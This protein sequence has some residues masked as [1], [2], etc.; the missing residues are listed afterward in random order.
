M[1]STTFPP[2]TNNT[3]R[4]TSPTQRKIPGVCRF[5]E[6][7]QNPLTTLSFKHRVICYL[8]SHAVTCPLPQVRATILKSLRDVP[9]ASK[10][11]MLIPV[12]KQVFEAPGQASTSTDQELFTTIAHT[13]DKNAAK[14]LNDKEGALW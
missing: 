2:S 14:A 4:N 5:L 8:V 1:I 3:L 7:L 12:F 9:D 10:A 11:S 6:C 13:F